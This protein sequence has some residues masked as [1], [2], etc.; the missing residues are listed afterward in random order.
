MANYIVKEQLKFKSGLVANINALATTSSAVQG[1]PHYTT[2]SR[3]LYVYDGY[4]NIRVH[5]L[6]MAITF[7]DEI[8][9]FN[10]EIIWLL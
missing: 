4:N 3:G 9:I 5:G 6:D 2:D 1:E 7:E 8:I 10:G